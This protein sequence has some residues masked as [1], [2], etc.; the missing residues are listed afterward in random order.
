MME[1]RKRDD[2]DTTQKLETRVSDKLCCRV[3]ELCRDSNP[4]PGGLFINTAKPAVFFK[5]CNWG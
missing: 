1:G 5:D 3:Y 2:D 4:P